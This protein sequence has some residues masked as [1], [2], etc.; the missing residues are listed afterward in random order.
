MSA[1]TF[2]LEEIREK[3]T[4][5][6]KFDLDKFLRKAKKLSKRENSK[7]KE[8]EHLLINLIAYQSMYRMIDLKTV[9]KIYLQLVETDWKLEDDINFPL[10]YKVDFLYLLTSIFNDYG[11]F[12][13]SE[14]TLK[15]LSYIQEKYSENKFIAFRFI[16]SLLGR[17]F[18]VWTVN[19]QNLEEY[20]NFIDK[21]ADKYDFTDIQK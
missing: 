14:K 16:L 20:L 2:N 13:R 21:F 15:R 12:T 7:T 17:S 19:Y 5:M 6:G 4:R 10:Y 1:Y 11:H 9:E 8:I 3:I 18:D